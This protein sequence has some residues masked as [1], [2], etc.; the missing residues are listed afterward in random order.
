MFDHSHSEMSGKIQERHRHRHRHGHR[1]NCWIV[2]WSFFNPTPSSIILSSVWQFSLHT[3]KKEKKK[4]ERKK[5][6]I[7]RGRKCEHK[8]KWLISR[9]K[10]SEWSQKMEFERQRVKWKDWVW[11]RKSEITRVILKE[12]EWNKKNEF[13]RE[14]VK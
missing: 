2:R 14:R 6:I 1:L 8:W 12:K 7:E 4:S 9:E 10:E 13:K 11:E 3:G 5:N